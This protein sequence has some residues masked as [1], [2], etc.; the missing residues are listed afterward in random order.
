MN[1]PGCS[2]APAKG[3]PDRYAAVLDLAVAKPDSGGST[4]WRPRYV[5]EISLVLGF[6]KVLPLS[7]KVLPMF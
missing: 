4:H 6:S 2:R 5:P 3:A 7:P 1:A